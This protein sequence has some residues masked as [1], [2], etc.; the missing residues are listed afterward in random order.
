MISLRLKIY[1]L[2]AIFG[3]IIVA[4]I[5][6]YYTA[7]DLPPYPKK[8]ISEEGN[9]LTGKEQI[10]AGQQVWQKYGLMDL[11]SVWGHGTYRGPDFTAQALHNM[12][13]N[14]REKMAKDKF[15]K[16]YSTLSTETKGSVDAVVIKQIKTNRYD[17]ATDT[18]TLSPLQEYALLENRKFYSDLFNLG[19]K[20]GPIRAGTIK[21]PQERRNLADFFFWTSWCAGTIRPGDN[22]TYTNNWPHDPDVGNFVSGKSIIW[23]AISLVIF[24]LG[25]GLMIY[26]FHRYKFNQGALPFKP[27]PALALAAGSISSSQK[28][29]VKYFLVVA[30][31]FF[32]QVNMGGLM[33]H[34]TV[35]PDSFYGFD[36]VAK[37]IPYNWV[38]TWHLQ[39][40]IFWISVT[41][42]GMTLFVAPRVGG[43][44]PVGQGLLVDILFVA[45]L[46]IVVGSL[47]GEVL[48]IKGL[49][50]KNW[51]WLGH[52]GWEYLELGRLW[53]ILLLAGLVIWLFLV[54]R[55]LKDHFAAGQDKWGLP[56]FLAYSGVAVVGF[57]SFGL[58]YN[59]DSH[60]TIAD[61]WRWWVV[62]TWVEG[63]FEFFAA[64]AIVFVMVNLGLVELKN[65]L[66]TVY[67]TVGLALGAGIIGVG[68]HYYWFGEPSFWLALGSTTSAL[69]PV[70]ILLLLA[71][72]WHSQKA[73]VTAGSS[74]PYRYPL[75]FLMASVIWEFLGG[76][77]MGLS[78]TTPIINYYEHATYLTV[79]HGHT[80]LFGTYGMLSIGLLLFSMRGL[81]TEKGWDERYI[82]IT[83]WGT[84]IG[85]IIMFAGTLLPIGILQV[86][87]NI[88]YGFWH[89]RSN[90]FWE[91]DI[92]QLIGQ[93]RM[94]PDFLIITGSGALLLFMLKAIR[95]IKPVTIK[96]GEKF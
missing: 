39:L 85:L 16:P 68:H 14:M 79:N 44:E 52:Q 32:L 47:T 10:M 22:H 90:A 49:I 81:V 24:G 20:R 15:D 31:L 93:T 64:A 51:F 91:Q 37:F 87:D 38:K 41:W 58:L 46:V 26:I 72:V 21:N 27:E 29:V 3:A 50:D 1:F 40:A 70:P 78:I 59:P 73:L 94:L 92:I 43:K 88:K 65:G 8:V 25:L 60:L 61:F 56:H 67:L 57:F 4:L 69:E 42:M 83:F 23:S 86:L 5:G 36:S 82:K 80:A 9:L 12:G 18:L 6:Y 13:L 34:Y 55:A 30:A 17:K 54:V 35:H 77:V 2:T 28:K 19:D 89:A 96:P 33:A 66:R 76:G 63:A 45:L 71:G 11:G 48:G 74:F 95:H 7:Q 53:Q 75:M 84:N 62:H